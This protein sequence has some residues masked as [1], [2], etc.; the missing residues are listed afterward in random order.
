[1]SPNTPRALNCG[2]YFWTVKFKDIPRPAPLEGGYILQHVDATLHV[3]DC[4]NNDI[5]Q[6]RANVW[7]KKKP[8]GYG[9]EMWEAFV[10]KP[11]KTTVAGRDEYSMRVIGDRTKGSL[12]VYGDY[13]Y[14]YGSIPTT[15]L[16]LD[17][18]REANGLP[19]SYSNPHAM[20]SAKDYS[21]THNIHI[22]WDCC[23]EC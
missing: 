7:W 14:I 19:S 2:G 1:M 23:D 8:G 12:D 15:D 16:P 21:G 20:A 4:N 11:G 17:G 5:T 3:E 6:S 18:P 10:I 9:Y 13:T 22:R